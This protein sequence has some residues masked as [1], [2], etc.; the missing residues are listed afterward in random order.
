MDV[1]TRFIKTG[2]NT[3]AFESASYDQNVD[4]IIDPLVEVNS[5]F[6]GGSDD[7]AASGVVLDKSG[8][9]YITGGT[10]SPDFPTKIPF[11]Q[12]TNDSTCWFLTS[13]II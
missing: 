11:L 4:L 7:D 9:A 5:T 10:Y 8:M 6:I 1:Q 12:N 3:F 13:L 2:K